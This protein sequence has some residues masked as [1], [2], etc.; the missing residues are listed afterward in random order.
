MIQNIK[1]KTYNFSASN[2][3]TE[4]KGEDGSFLCTSKS[5][6]DSTKPFRIIFISK[7]DSAE[8]KRN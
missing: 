4:Y 7:L 3:F 6:L 1:K 2:D 5:N 8:L